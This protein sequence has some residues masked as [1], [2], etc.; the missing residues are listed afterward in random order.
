MSPSL[1]SSSSP[2]STGPAFPQKQQ[3][4]SMTTSKTINLHLPRR[5]TLTFFFFF[6]NR[7][8]S[9][10]SIPRAADRKSWDNGRNEAKRSDGTCDCV[11]ILSTPSQP[12]KARTD[13]FLDLERSHT[14]CSSDHH[15]R[16]GGRKRG[17]GRGTKLGLSKARILLLVS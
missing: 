15:F 8:S 10:R 7:A 3:G 4:R 13:F 17:G 2:P 6:F 11:I 16:E 1:H 12:N 5:K 14:H 9:P